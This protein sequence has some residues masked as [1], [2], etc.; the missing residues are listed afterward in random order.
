MKTENRAWLILIFLA[1]VWGSS[2]ILMKKSM[3]PSSSEMVLDPYQVGALR[4]LIAGLVMLPFSIRHLKA[5][6]KNDI[7]LLLIVG[8]CGNLLPATLFTVA[9]TRIDSS[10]AGMLNMGTS[11]FVVILGILL[12]KSS[13]SKFQY[14]GII[15]G[16][17]GLYLVLRTQISFEQDQLGHALLILLATLF[18]ATSLITI[19]FKLQHLQPITI[20][21]LAFLLILLPALIGVIVFDSFTPVF[22]H[23]EGF[24]ALGFLSVL[25]VVG[26]A[27]AVFLFNSLVAISS[28]IFATGVTYLM[29]VVAIFI[30]VLDG[31]DFKFTNIPW[32][33]MIIGGVYLLNKGNKKTAK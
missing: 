2:F 3:F 15:L 7:I 26:T 1:L 31:D 9:E 25:A 20:T 33:L 21:A 8:V 23:P 16:A 6:K 14:L 12:F 32:I 24:K 5:L 19:K 10:L 28:H 17:S 22:N 18:Y 30:G 13:P 11:F 29:P 27:L 4:I